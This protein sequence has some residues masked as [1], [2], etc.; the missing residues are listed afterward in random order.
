MTVAKR[1]RSEVT[2][3]R[4]F[5]KSAQHSLEARERQK[6]RIKRLQEV[7]LCS[8]CRKFRHWHKECPQNTNKT[9]VR[10]LTKGDIILLAKVTEEMLSH[11]HSMC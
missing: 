1:N 10:W 2:K 3:A 8:I 4:G 5:Y 7:L 9:Y 11:R 6:E